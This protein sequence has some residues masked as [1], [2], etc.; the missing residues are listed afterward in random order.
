MRN[1]PEFFVVVVKKKKKS[2]L[3]RST[4]VKKVEQNCLLSFKVVKKHFNHA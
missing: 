2:T 3:K 1:V 4:I